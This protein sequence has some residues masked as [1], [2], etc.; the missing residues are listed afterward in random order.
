MIEI[1]YRTDLKLTLLR[2]FDRATLGEHLAAVRE[3]LVQSDEPPLDNQI[4]VDARRLLDYALTTP[5]L[6]HLGIRVAALYVYHPRPLTIHI[7]MGP[8]WQRPIAQRF[9]WFGLASGQ[10]RTT[11]YEAETTLLQAVHPDADS[12]DA[13]FPR[14]CLQAVYRAI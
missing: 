2:L 5:E 8:P 7:L 1:S 9:R 4:L 11:L 12:L 6:M 13:L 14:D 3:L 10:I